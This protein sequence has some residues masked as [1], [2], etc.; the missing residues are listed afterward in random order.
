MGEYFDQG[1]CSFP[2]PHGKPATVFPDPPGGVGG[3][4]PAMLSTEA[5]LVEAEGINIAMIIMASKPEAKLTYRLI[6]TMG[7]AP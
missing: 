3:V 7:E 1:I 2:G 4:I 5:V 6:T